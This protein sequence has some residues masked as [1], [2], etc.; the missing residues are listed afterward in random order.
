MEDEFPIT[1]HSVR[2]A[3]LYPFLRNTVNRYREILTPRGRV[4]RDFNAVDADEM[5]VG[6]LW[7]HEVIRAATSRHDEH[8]AV[9]PV[10]LLASGNTRE[11]DLLLLNWRGYRD[12]NR[13]SSPEKQTEASHAESRGVPSSSS[14][15]SAARLRRVAQEGGAVR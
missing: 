5:G 8:T 14:S 3:Y 10:P 6:S 4:G 9:L 15:S 12:A 2:E 7:K 13:D 1:I 11:Q